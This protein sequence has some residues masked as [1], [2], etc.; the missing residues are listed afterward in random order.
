MRAHGRQ[1]PALALARDRIATLCEWMAHEGLGGLPVTCRVSE[2]GAPPV[3]DRASVSPLAAATLLR[4][5]VEDLE[6]ALET[7]P[8]S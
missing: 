4:V 8:V 2:T 7:A 3:A 6:H 1:R 5:W